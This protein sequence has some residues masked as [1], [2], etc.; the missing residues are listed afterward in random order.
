MATVLVTGATGF[1]GKRVCDALVGKGDEII[2]ISRNPAR[3]HTALSAAKTVYGW[4]ASTDLL[5]P[6]ATSEVTAV[7]HLAGETIAGRWNAKK[8]LRIRDSRILST[9][10]LVNSLAD[11]QNKPA[12]LVCASA[13]GYYGE[14]GDAQ[15][16]ETSPSGSDFLANVC[17]EWETE[18]L[19]AEALGI[20]VVLVRI[21]LVLG[22][23]G[24]LLKQVL[25][26]F[27]MGVG[28]KLGRGNQWMSWV[29]VDDVVGIILHVLENPEISGSLN[30]TA[31]APVRN[32]EFTKT[33]GSVLRRPTLFPV[34]IIALKVMM[35]EFA[36]F[37]LLS[38]QV[39]PEKTEASGYTFQ[40][41]TLEPAL[42][43]CV[44]ER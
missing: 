17:K 26:P 31:P 1:I 36:N 20:R 10:C 22:R 39:L 15:L 19:K 42:R 6:E 2:G 21:G 7:V 43:A 35:G 11:A 9:R 32:T 38:Q 24:G 4:N 30:A 5:P 18:A 16:T 34:P 40:Y 28:G 29:H 44:E 27:K 3:A 33:L 23:E 25:P 37:V 12:V 13:I 14:S 41:Q 8:K